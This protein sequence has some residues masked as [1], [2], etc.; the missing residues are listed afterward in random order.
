[1]QR[2]IEYTLPQAGPDAGETLT[3]LRLTIGPMSALQ[4]ARYRAELRRV[5]AWLREE[6]EIDL[7]DDALSDD[8]LQVVL[9]ARQYAYMVHTAHQVETAT[10]APDEE[11][12]AW[13]PGQLPDAWQGVEAFLAHVPADLFLAWN[14]A[15]EACNRG[16]LWGRDNEKKR[17]PGSVTVIT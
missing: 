1:M 13:T 6:Q 7:D 11:P 17:R 10:C 15:A 3:V 12:E 9:L 14:E 16:L 4:L 2:I 5:D 8:A